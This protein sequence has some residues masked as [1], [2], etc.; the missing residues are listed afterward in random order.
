MMDRP[1]ATQKG[2]EMLGCLI[3][4]TPAWPPR[5][6]PSKRA[7]I[8]GHRAQGADGVLISLTGRLAG[9]GD[10]KGNGHG[11]KGGIGKL[12][13]KLEHVSHSHHQRA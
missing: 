12:N 5:R 7:R 11:A 1:L 2:R 9:K 6:L 4:R 8:T 10:Q 3:A 13:Q